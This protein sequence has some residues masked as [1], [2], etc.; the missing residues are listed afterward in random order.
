MSLKDPPGRQPFMM[1]PPTLDETLQQAVAWLKQQRKVILITHIDADGMSAGAIMSRV[2]TRLGIQH[3]IHPVQTLDAPALRRI[4][5]DDTPL[6]LT[7]L[8]SGQVSLLSQLDQPILILDHH[9]PQ[10]SFHREDHVHVN[11]HEHGIDG[12]REIS[13]AGVAYLLARTLGMRDLAY[14]GIIGALGDVQEQDGFHGLNQLILQ[15]AEEEGSIIREQTIS[16]YGLH[17]RPLARLLAYNRDLALKGVQGSLAA[18]ERFLE[19]LGIPSM[20]EGKP[21]HYYQLSRSERQR[22]IAALL[23]Q[24]GNGSLTPAT[25]YLLTDEPPGSPLRDA[26]EFAT[27]LNAC[28]RMDLPSIGIAAVLNE[29]GAR[30][31]A[32]AIQQEYRR[33]ISEAMQWYQQARSEG[34]II[35]D[36]GL[37]IIDGR[38]IIRPQLIGTIASIISYDDTTPPGMIILSIAQAE[39]GKCKVSIRI[40]KREEENMHAI[41]QVIIRGIPGAAAGGHEN[42]AGA[43]LP[44]THV[45]QLIRNARS[46]LAKRN[47]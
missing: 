28:G 14:A 15:D 37:M 17:S 30:R 20:R 45:A 23:V 22:L 44:C 31:K 12:G 46:L 32:L 36:E 21:I 16:L 13:G 7:D 10:G 19:Q 43:I 27:V 2:L 26:R 41:M 39:E 47:V 38:G 3:S 4:I 24:Q 18:A 1:I 34:L 8:G 11:P 6:V 42:A 5:Q 9:E 25:A 33:A 40:A 29:P 35:Q